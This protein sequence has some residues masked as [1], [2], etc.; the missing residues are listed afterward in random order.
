MNDIIVGLDIG[1]SNI[2]V[3]IGELTDGRNLEIIGYA[4]HH[5]QGLRNG[6]IVNQDQARQ[7]IKETIED[8]E[9]KAGVTVEEVYATLGGSQ[10]ES[11]NN[12]GNT[13]IDTTGKNRALEVTELT[14]KNAIDSATAVEIPLDKQPI[15]VIPQEYFVDNVSYQ[16]N[17]LGNKGHSLKVSVHLITASKTACSSITQC[18]TQS[19][20]GL[21]KIMLK[22]LVAATAVVHEDEMETGSVLIDLGGSSTDVIVLNKGAPVFSA[23]VPVG[24]NLVTNDIAMVTH[25]SNSMA[26]KI[27]IE[28]GACMVSEQ[29]MNDEVVLPGIGGKAPELIT[30]AQLCEIIQPRYAEIFTL[31]RHEVIRNSGLKTLGGNIVLTGGGSLMDG[32]VDLCKEIWRT[33]SVRLGVSPDKGGDDKGYR[34]SDFAG[35]VGI[36]LANCNRSSGEKARKKLGAKESGSGL[37][38]KFGDFFKNF[39]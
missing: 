19:G 12:T 26:E 14:K 34:S 6:V 5:S 13:P 8:A 39:F 2:R 17:P 25:I 3:V 22:P 11:I 31:V 27:K 21:R 23:S 35:C 38:K 36:V 30:K 37:K 29:N 9:M 15:H 7:I 10:I 1:T 32:V 16:Q 20:L 33:D 28:K 4:K 18:V 24:G